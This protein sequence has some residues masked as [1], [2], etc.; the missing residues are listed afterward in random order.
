MNQ[1]Q[2]DALERM[3]ERVPEILEVLETGKFPRHLIDA[4]LLDTTICGVPE[5]VADDLR[6]ALTKLPM[7]PAT[8]GA[9]EEILEKLIG[10]ATSAAPT[11][12]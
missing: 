1:E 5:D 4:M 11:V 3:R 8:R 2:L 10:L 7:V 9:A 12:R 6:S